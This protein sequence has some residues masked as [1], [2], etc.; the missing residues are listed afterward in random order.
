L[1]TGDQRKG[2]TEREVS[3]ISEKRGGELRQAEDGAIS[4]QEAF[5]VLKKKE[6]KK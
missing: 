6:R 1:Y 4:T 3:Y 2:A 5:V